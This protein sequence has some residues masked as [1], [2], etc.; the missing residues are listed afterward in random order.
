MRHN[1]VNTRPNCRPHL[2]A[3]HAVLGQRACRQVNTQ[4][5]H[6][7]NTGRGEI[8]RVRARAWTRPVCSAGGRLQHTA[9]HKSLCVAITGSGLKQRTL[10]RRRN[11][12]ALHQQAATASKVHR[13]SSLTTKQQQHKLPIRH[14]PVL[15]LH[16]TVAVPMVSAALRCRTCEC[17]AQGKGVQTHSCLMW[18]QAVPGVSAALRRG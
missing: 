6:C 8:S 7:Y 13:C 1:S 16:T 3:H 11:P 4:H 10:P 14:A 5:G 17:G 9:V 18:Q 15:S 2:E 12:P